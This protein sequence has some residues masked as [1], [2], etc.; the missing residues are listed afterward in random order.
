MMFETYKNVAPGWLYQTNLTGPEMVY[1][2]KYVSYYDQFHSPLPFIRTLFCETHAHF[3]TVL[4]IG[5]G[6]G[7]FLKEAR[8]NGYICYGHD[9]SGYPVPKGVAF[10]EDRNIPVDLVT[11]FDC[12]EHFPNENLW[13]VL[14]PL[15]CRYLCISVPWCHWTH[16][17]KSFEHWRHRKPNEHFHH[18]DVSGLTHLLDRSGF[19]PVLFSN[20]EDEIRRNTTSK[21]PNILTVMARRY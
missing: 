8:A 15:N 11:M 21:L 12:L 19:E 6:N 4:D 1:D 18:F 5:Y 14:K 2:T 16:D 17:L 7:S 3:K 9:I 20:V 10:T 13:E